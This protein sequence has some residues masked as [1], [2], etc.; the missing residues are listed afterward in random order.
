MASLTTT[1]R[2]AGVEW[3]DGLWPPE[4]V[5]AIFRKL[6]ALPYAWGE[7]DQAGVPPTGLVSVFAPGDPLV[8][9]FLGLCPEP[10]PTARLERAYVNLFLP[11]ELPYFHQDN[12][13]PG[14][15]TVLYFANPEWEPQQG[16]E[17]QFFMDDRILGVLPVPG[18]VCA[19]DARIRHRATSFRDG[20]RFTV[21]LKFVL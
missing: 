10:L 21:A 1:A 14:H 8:A 18:R 11:R 19:F 2:D 17:T 3:R 6:A 15:V 12:A 4:K 5:E 13:N 9:E 20:A 7:I 16:G